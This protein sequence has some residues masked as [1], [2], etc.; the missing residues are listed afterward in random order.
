M[1]RNYVLETANAPL[2]AVTVLLAGASAGRLRWRQAYASGSQAFYFLD[3]GA[4]AEWGIGTVTV[5]TP[6]TLSRDIV[7]GNTLGTTARV[8][9]S[10]AISVYNE[11]PGEK[12]VYIDAAGFA[13]APGSLFDPSAGGVPVGSG[14]DW[15]GPTAPAGYLFA[16]GQAIS[17]VTYHRLYDVMG[18]TYGAGDGASTFNLPDKR[19]RVSYPKDIGSPQRISS[20]IS[21]GILGATGGDQWL[22]THAHP[23]NWV[24]FGHNHTVT[25]PSHNHNYSDPAHVHSYTS[26]QPVAGTGLTT[27]GLGD[28]QVSPVTNITSATG[29]NISISLHQTGVGL[30][31]ASSNIV[32]SIAVSGAGSSQNL[33]PG[34][35]CNY[36][37]F[38]GAV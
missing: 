7:I 9:F 29:T 33:P 17:R 24:D 8:S 2:T 11:I 6:D 28:T 1:I 21:S 5:G 36:I 14:M 20:V 38:A 31:S 26:W 3:D 10:G 13:R 23:L 12:M 37:I 27:F 15:W 18:T 22:Q 32:A 4:A 35:V 30:L 16:F 19:G 34:I 25:D